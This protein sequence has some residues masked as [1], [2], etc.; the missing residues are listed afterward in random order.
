[1]TTSIHNKKNQRKVNSPKQQKQKNINVKLKIG[2][3][4][5]RNENWEFEND[6]LMFSKFS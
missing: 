4:G 1:M 6:C 5:T 2:R 3:K